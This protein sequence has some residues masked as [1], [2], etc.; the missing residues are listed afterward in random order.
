MAPPFRIIVGNEDARQRAADVL[1]ALN[2]DK[3]PWA[4]SIAP[5]KRNRSLEQN[6]LLWKVYTI[7]A[8]ETGHS[9][10]EIHDWCR[11]QFLPA[12]FVEINGQAHEVR[13]STATLKVDEMTEYLNR[14]MSWA[15]A[16][17][18]IVLPIHEKDAA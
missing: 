4:V 7:V 6:N 9:P 8:E 17:L 13:R 1:T 18:G 15:T 2:L 14:V 5:Y 3:C 10:E 16:D 12:R 11:Q